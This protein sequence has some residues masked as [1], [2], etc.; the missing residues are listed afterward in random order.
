M[1]NILTLTPALAV[2]REEMNQA[3]R[4]LDESLSDVERA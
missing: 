2:T 4:I 3:L 1:G